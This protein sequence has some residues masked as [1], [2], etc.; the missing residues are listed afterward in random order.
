[1][2]P[3]GASCPSRDSFPAYSLGAAGL[4]AINAGLHM[5]GIMPHLHDLK[6][7]IDE[8]YEEFCEALLEEA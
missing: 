1:M 5:E 8:V 3:S 4:A 6:L 2:P 7:C